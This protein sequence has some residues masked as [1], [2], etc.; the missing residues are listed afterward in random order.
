MQN[1]NFLTLNSPAVQDIQDNQNDKVLDS[2][3]E[4]DVKWELQESIYCKL[5]I[6]R[7]N[8]QDGCQL[9][10]FSHTGE[11]MKIREQMTHC[12]IISVFKF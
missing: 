12:L 1:S 4:M 8:S 7:F 5:D 9:T 6:F 2:N 3:W 11:E 10:L